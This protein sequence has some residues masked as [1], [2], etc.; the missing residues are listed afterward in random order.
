MSHRMY[1][2]YMKIVASL[3]LAAVFACIL[4]LKG[5][6]LTRYTVKRSGV[7]YLATR[8]DTVTSKF[9]APRRPCQQNS[10]LNHTYSHEILDSPAVW[11]CRPAY[12]ND[13]QRDVRT[14]HSTY[15]DHCTDLLRRTYGDVV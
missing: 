12:R 6:E 9:V 7:T 10:M 3:S 8:S 14:D 5:L 13:F 4:T 11:T 2:H 1:Q 15:S